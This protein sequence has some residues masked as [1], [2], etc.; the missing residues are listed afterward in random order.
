MAI[1]KII[2]NP[3]KKEI[4]YQ[5]WSDVFNEW[6]T[7]DTS[8]S[9]NSKLLSEELTHGFF[10][11]RAKQILDAIVEEYGSDNEEIKVVF[12]GSMDE[13]KDLEESCAGEELQGKVSVV[14]SDLF[15]ENARDILPEVRQIFQEISPLIHQCASEDKISR[16]LNRFTDASS[17]VVPVCVLGNYSAGKSSFIN[18]LIGSEILPCGTEPITAK[19]YKI[20]RSKYSDRASIH[21]VANNQGISI[22]FKDNETT[23]DGVKSRNPLV[24]LLQEALAHSEN[25][26]IVDRVRESLSIINDYESNTENDMISDLIEVEIPFISG[27]LAQSQHPFVLFDTPG[28]N[29]ASNA[30]HLQVLKQ[31]MANMTNGLPIFL[32]TPEALDST[33]NEHLYHII[34]DMEE[35]DNRF[36]MIVVNK[37]DGLKPQTGGVLAVEQERTLS[38][39]V[40]R[41]LYSGGLFYVSSILGLGAKNNGEFRDESFA[42]TFEEQVYKYNDP[43]ARRYRTLYTLNIMP[44]QLKHRAN[45]EAAEQQDLVYVNSG[46]F[47]VEREIENFAGKYSSYNKCFQSQM[48]LRNVIRITEDEIE[49]KKTEKDCDRQLIKDKLE[50]DKQKLV[51]HLESTADQKRTGYDGL[52]DEH[53]RSFLSV[54]SNNL[55]IEQLERKEAELNSSYEEEMGYEERRDDARKAFAIVGENLRSRFNGAEKKFSFSTLKTVASGLR[56]DTGSAIDSYS[57]QRET[58]HKVDRAVAERLLDF[59]AETYESSLSDTYELLERT[60]QT[61]W[62]NKTEELRMCLADIVT[63]SD[64]LTEERREELER[65]IITYQRI[66]FRENHAK[67]IFKKA[68][69]EKKIL[70]WQLDRLNLSKIVNVYRESYDDD[71]AERCKSIKE[72]HR[73]SAHNWIRSL[74]DLIIEN[75]VQYSPE[76]SKMAKRIE[77][78]TNQIEDLIQCQ[79][80]LEQYT[81]KL[82]EMMD[83]KKI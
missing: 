79:I 28:S 56:D 38:Q 32:C 83:W 39:A 47:S 6:T 58:R 19:I 53:I 49:D 52:Y 54:D 15:L 45:K 37:A 75:L 16:D 60:S 35:L 55:S 13:F 24:D 57:A 69:F 3:Y 20:A 68:K 31:A 61:Y 34:R 29:S 41:N 10:P 48:F 67:D 74:L 81:E 44:A 72:S 80:K 50:E 7:I 11:F 9:K 78:L 71:I 22:C 4:T 64:V 2:S 30:K 33:D 63:G 77:S 42:E 1:I 46:L 14:K 12:E 40:P 21:C 62:T 76:L 66:V 27:V 8:V 70:F 51:R 26:G 17:D 23:F 5:K 59:V 65:I 73:E 36:T 43:T 82:C 25:A 18:A